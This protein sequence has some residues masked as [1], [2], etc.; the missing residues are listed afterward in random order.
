MARR[1]ITH[2]ATLLLGLATAMAVMAALPATACDDA[3]PRNASVT[4]AS[5]V[6]TQ[7]LVALPVGQQIAVQGNAALVEIRQQIELV[8]IEISAPTERTVAWAEL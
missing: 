4:K 3:K 8:P 1:K 5:L 6:P 2:S 7:A